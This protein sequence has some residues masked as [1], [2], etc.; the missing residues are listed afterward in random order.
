MKCLMPE[1][2]RTPASSRRADID[3]FIRDMVARVSILWRS[4]SHMQP[5][6]RQ[7]LTQYAAISIGSGLGWGLVLQQRWYVCGGS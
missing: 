1:V 6:R 5:T 4:L 3:Y 2:P 7:Q